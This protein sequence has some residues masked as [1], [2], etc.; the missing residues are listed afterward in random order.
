MTPY[1]TVGCRQYSIFGCKLLNYCTRLG[2]SPLY[3]TYCSIGS[4]GS[5]HASPPSSVHYGL[6]FFR[7]LIFVFCDIAL[8]T[9]MTKPYHTRPAQPSPDNTHIIS[10]TSLQIKEPH[11]VSVTGAAF[12][13]YHMTRTLL[14]VQ[15]L[16]FGDGDI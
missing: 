11:G 4:G 2:L 5:A 7:S 10:V 3:K 6:I 15:L 16:Y 13:L 14:R 8:L 9:A 1:N 12:S